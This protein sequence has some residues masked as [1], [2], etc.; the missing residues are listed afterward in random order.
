MA[1]LLYKPPKTEADDEPCNFFQNNT[2]SKT[3]QMKENLNDYGVNGHVT[4][5]GN[6]KDIKDNKERDKLEGLNNV[7]YVRDNGGGGLG[8]SMAKLEHGTD[9]I[10]KL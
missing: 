10:T 8:D 2:D 7:A 1:W 6:N 5:Y 9:V 3:D 4:K